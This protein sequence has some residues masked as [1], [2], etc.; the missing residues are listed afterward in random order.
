ARAKHLLRAIAP[1]IRPQT[2][3]DR[4]VHCPRRGSVASGY[5]QGLELIGPRA[6]SSLMSALEARG[7]EDMTRQCASAAIAAHF[8][9]LRRISRV[10]RLRMMQTPRIQKLSP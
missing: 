7:P 4:R 6:A 9:G 8:G 10:A 5:P 1:R 2:R 3:L